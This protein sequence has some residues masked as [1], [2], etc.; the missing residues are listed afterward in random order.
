MAVGAGLIAI[1]SS[2]GW[3]TMAAIL[4]AG[5]A[6]TGIS[7]WTWWRTTMTFMQFLYDYRRWGAEKPAKK[8]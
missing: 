6:V 8:E 5:T 3:G 7:G 1:G 2:P 4:A